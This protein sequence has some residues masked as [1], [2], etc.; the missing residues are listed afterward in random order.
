MLIKLF[1]SNSPGLLIPLIVYAI[2][3]KFPAFFLSQYDGAYQWLPLS[4]LIF[5]SL[6]S[7]TKSS[8]L[9]T[10]LGLIVIITQSLIFNQWV[11]RLKVFPG[12]NYLP[13]LSYFLISSLLISFTEFSPELLSNFLFLLFIMRL[14]DIYKS[15]SA[16]SEV[17]DLS[18]IIGLSALIYL[19][20]LSWLFI[21]FI[22]LSILRPFVW[23][24]WLMGF[25]G[26]SNV[27]LLLWVYYYLSNST[28]SLA[29]IFAKP[30]ITK[31]FVYDF[32]VH[33]TLYP[34]LAIFAIGL[35]IALAF[36][37]QAYMKSPIQ[38]R[39]HINILLWSFP[40]LLGSSIFTHS[41]SIR[42]LIILSVPLS[43][44]IGYLFTHNKRLRLVETYHWFFVLLTI[45][46][47]YW[48]LLFK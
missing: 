15:N 10:I 39:K 8:V 2:I 46:A 42:H 31:L 25:F 3:L 26:I 5:G 30:E 21:L 33:W 12:N 19:P 45:L 24:E 7:I 37:Q 48:S 29:A 22:G 16:M 38:T 27:F 40:I 47:N 14:F 35:L 41:I 44:I 43:I 6:Q 11:N 36:M 1:K 18:F 34:A 9:Y 4:D 28:Q 23:L 32:H 20:A 13:A 17:Y